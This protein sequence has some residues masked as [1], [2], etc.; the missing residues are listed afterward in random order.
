MFFVQLENVPGPFLK[1][2]PNCSNMQN[3]FQYHYLTYAEGDNPN[4]N[5]EVNLQ[6]LFLW[7]FATHFLRNSSEWLLA[8]LFN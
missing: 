3:A 4:I 6:Q 5:L 8:N 1:P 7:A 2:L